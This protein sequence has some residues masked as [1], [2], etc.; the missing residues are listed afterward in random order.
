[1]LHK[2]I[3]VPEEV[4]ENSQSP[5]SGVQDCFKQHTVR[6]HKRTV[7]LSISFFRSSGLLQRERFGKEVQTPLSSQ[8]PSSGV[9]DCFE[10]AEVREKKKVKSLSISFFRSSG[11]LP[12]PL[13]MAPPHVLDLSISFFRSSGLLPEG[14]EGGRVV[15]E[16]LNLLLQEFRIASRRNRRGASCIGNSQSPSSG[17]Q[18]CFLLPFLFSERLNFFSQSPSSGVQDCF[19]C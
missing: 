13:L 8:S 11:L 12:R 6:S 9:Q 5:S 19:I 10:K 3:E 18:D 7:Y 16:T 14:T 2:Y 1:M 17:V 4:P 15:L